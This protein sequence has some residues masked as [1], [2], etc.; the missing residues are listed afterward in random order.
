MLLPPGLHR[1][2][3]VAAGQV[4]LVLLPGPVALVHRRAEAALVEQQAAEVAGGEPHLHPPLAPK[5]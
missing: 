1:P 3:R 4:V 2:G 5:T